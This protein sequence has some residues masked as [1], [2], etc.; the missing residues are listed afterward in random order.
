MAEWLQVLL[1]STITALATGLGALPL[2][3]VDD[4]SERVLSLGSAVSG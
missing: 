4:V 2:V 3:F 1:F